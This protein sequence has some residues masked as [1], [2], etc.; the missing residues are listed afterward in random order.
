[1]SVDSELLSIVSLLEDRDES[2]VNGINERM[3]ER[4][5]SVLSDLSEIMN[6][7]KSI[8]KRKD[9]AEKIAYLSREFTLKA[10]EREGSL[11][12]PDFIKSILLINKLIITD[13]DCDGFN[14]FLQKI[15]SIISSEIAE[16]KTSV[17]KVE[18]FNVLF[19]SRF[20][21]SQSRNPDPEEIT[22]LIV[23]VLDSGYGDYVPILI[24]YFMVALYTGMNIYPVFYT[25]GIIP[26]YIENGKP[27]FYI[28]L[29][30][31]GKIVHQDDFLKMCKSDDLDVNNLKLEVRDTSVLITMYLEYLHII[32]SSL[33]DWDKVSL[34]IKAISFF[35][36]EHFERYNEEEEEE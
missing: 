21:I 7:E 34:V 35:P 33:R 19:F 18:L 5:A 32:Y 3:M 23:C 2:V 17:E 30:L 16:E 22:S 9:I 15:S 10:L 11:E 25:G 1:M 12:Y 20:D 13:I 31:Q 4:G 8:S 26:S 36:E 6:E 27:L 14:D 24:T 29:S 28:N